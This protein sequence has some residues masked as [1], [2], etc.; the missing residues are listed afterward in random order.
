MSFLIPRK[1]PNVR[2]WAAHIDPVS[3]VVTVDDQ[4]ALVDAQEMLTQAAAQ[5]QSILAHAHATAQAESQRVLAAAQAQALQ[6][7]A[8]KMVEMTSR[9]VEYLAGIEQEMIELVMGAVR[10]VVDGFNDQVQIMT[11]VRNALAVLR[12]QK[13]MTLHL[14]PDEAALVSAQLQE[15]LAIYPSVESLDV[16]ADE[17]V[18]RG[19]C[20][21]ESPM[22]SVKTS[23]QGQINALRQGLQGTLGNQA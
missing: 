3:T 19:S 16:L 7:Q 23:L 13:H 4:F 22:G 12:K 17:R 2:R 20:I 11:V 21:L 18:A 10:K 9:R 5:A 8:E 6:L 15:L 1:A 14:C